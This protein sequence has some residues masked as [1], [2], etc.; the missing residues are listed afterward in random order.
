VVRAEARQ[1]AS[2]ILYGFPAST[3]IFRGNGPLYTVGARDSALVV[4]QYGARKPAE[5]PSDEPMFGIART[6][7]ATPATTATPATP[8]APAAPSAVA[9]RGDSAARPDSAARGRD[10]S[11][12]AGGRTGGS[13]SGY[14][15][16]GMVRGQDEIVGQGAIFDVP[17]EKGRVIAFTFDPLHRYLN[18]HEFPLVWNALMNWNDRPQPARAVAASMLRDDSP[19]RASATR[20]AP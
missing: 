5:K 16:S 15:L 18:H 20:P 7:P 11:A 4:L 2:P 3:S 8:T 19:S 9:A 17:V 12:T 13:E 6:A 14:V 1:P 10:S